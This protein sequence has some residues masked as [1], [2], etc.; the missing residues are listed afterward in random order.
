[1][2]CGIASRSREFLIETFTQLRDDLVAEIR[3]STGGRPD[4]VGAGRRLAIFEALLDGLHG[5]AFPD[6]SALREYVAE[7]AEAV[8]DANDYVQA[9]LEHQAFAELIAELGSSAS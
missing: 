2:R 7:M 5:G 6:D 8:D 4:R 9:S 1:M 3:S